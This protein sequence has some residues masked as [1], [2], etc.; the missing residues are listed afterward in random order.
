MEGRHIL[1]HLCI[2]CICTKCSHTFLRKETI[3]P[4]ASRTVSQS[5]DKCLVLGAMQGL[6]L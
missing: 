2:I 1:F 5:E 6:T 4:E 3:G